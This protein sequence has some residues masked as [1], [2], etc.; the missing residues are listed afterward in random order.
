MTQSRQ[1]KAVAWLSVASN[2]ALVAGKLVIGL[3]IGS[4]GVHGNVIRVAPPLVMT[5][6]QADESLEIIEGALARLKLP[7]V[8]S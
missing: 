1:K 6:A 8:R 3:L 2:S 5:R 7:A 4:V